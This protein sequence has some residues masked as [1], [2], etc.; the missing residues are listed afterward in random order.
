MKKKKTILTHKSIVM[1]CENVCWPTSANH[2]RFTTARPA[3]SIYSLFLRVSVRGWPEGEVSLPPHHPAAD[4][5]EGPGLGWPQLC[6][7]VPGRPL[8]A[9]WE[10]EG[11]PG[12]LPQGDWLLETNV[13]VC[14]LG[15]RYLWANWTESSWTLCLW[16][17]FISY[18]RGFYQVWLLS[19]QFAQRLTEPHETELKHLSFPFPQN[20][21]VLKKCAQEYLTRVRKEEQRYQALKIHAEEK[22]DK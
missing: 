16:R 17:H 20:E 13:C 19:V 2:K 8:Q 14:V 18:L 1:Y 11:C 12:W 5:G 22:L 4:H 21:E 15:P 3:I 9:L 6:G 10:D 7:E